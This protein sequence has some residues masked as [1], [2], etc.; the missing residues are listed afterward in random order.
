MHYI[1]LNLSS[2]IGEDYSAAGV[3]IDPVL[4]IRLFRESVVAILAGIFFLTTTAGIYPAF[5]ASLAPPVESLK[6]I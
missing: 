4:K 5:K 2:L 3:I 1:G 6:R